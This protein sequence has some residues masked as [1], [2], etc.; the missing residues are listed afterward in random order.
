MAT[1]IFTVDRRMTGIFRDP[2]LPNDS[3]LVQILRINHNESEYEVKI[4]DHLNELYT[5]GA[6]FWTSWDNVNEVA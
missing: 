6:I 4:I 2:N 3:V 5:N 1:N